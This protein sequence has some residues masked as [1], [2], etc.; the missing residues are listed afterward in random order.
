LRTCRC[1]VW[2]RNLSL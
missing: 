2:N 1:G